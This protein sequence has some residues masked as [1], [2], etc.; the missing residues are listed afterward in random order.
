MSESRA[1][2]SIIGPGKIDYLKNNDIT[3]YSTHKNKP[4]KKYPNGQKNLI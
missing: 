2:N 4:Q 1:G 3:L